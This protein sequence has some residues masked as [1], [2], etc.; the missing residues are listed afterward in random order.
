[1]TLR[2]RALLGD[3]AVNESVSGAAAFSG[4]AMLGDGA[5]K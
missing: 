3:G 1:M 4:G 2:W 5:V